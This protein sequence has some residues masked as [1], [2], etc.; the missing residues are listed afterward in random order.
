[1]WKPYLKVVTKKAGHAVHIL[2]RFHIAKHMSDAID[3]VRRAEVRSLRQR[4]RQPLLTKARWVLLKRRAN[5]TRAQRARV[6]ELLHHN[7][8]AV[9][10]M[11]LR[12]DF[13]RCWAY[14][15]HIGSAC[16]STTGVG[17][18][19]ARDRPDEEGRPDA[20]PPSPPDPQLVSGAP[21]FPPPSSRAS[22]TKRN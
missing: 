10:V 1:M 7:L 2:D 11:L 17:R 14:R 6:R 15:D 9:R 8:R 12:E 21:R 18:C 13:Q 19:C 20:P 16:S 5:Q 3:Q 4:G 22:T